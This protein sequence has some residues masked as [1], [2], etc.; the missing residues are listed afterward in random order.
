MASVRFSVS[1]RVRMRVGVRVRVSVVV[2]VRI[3]DRTQRPSLVDHAV[4]ADFG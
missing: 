4:D 2:G 1:V 3:K